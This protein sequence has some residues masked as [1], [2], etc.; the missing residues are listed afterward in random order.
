[1]LHS[2]H[3]QLPANKQAGPTRPARVYAHYHL[4]V[5]ALE[6]SGAARGTV[7]AVMAEPAP[8]EWEMVYG[9]GRVPAE[10]Q[11]QFSVVGG[12]PG[13]LV[14][15]EVSWSLPRPGRRRAKHAP[16]ASSRLVSVLEAAG[17]RVSAPCPVF[18][19]CG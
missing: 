14:E 4:R 1:M 5:E 8:A 9:P 17:E 7:V 19:E 6:S 18:G 15:I 11:R 13:E 10:P 16:A 12:L 2:D 3:A